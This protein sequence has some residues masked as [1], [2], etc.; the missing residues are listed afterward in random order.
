MYSSIVKKLSLALALSLWFVN[1]GPDIARASEALEQEKTE[2]AVRISHELTEEGLSAKIH[3]EAGNVGTLLTDVRM[4]KGSGVK[5]TG[6]DAKRETSETEEYSYTVTENGTYRFKVTYLEKVDSL[7]DVPILDEDVEQEEPGET[8][9]SSD[10]SKSTASEADTASPS[11]GGKADQELDPDTEETGKTEIN[12]DEEEMEEIEKPEN[13]DGAE[14]ENSEKPGNNDG[15]DP[16]NSEKPENSDGEDP[17]NS[18]AAPEAVWLKL[19]DKLFPPMEVWGAE[20]EFFW[21]EKSLIV[22]YTVDDIGEIKNPAELNSQVVTMESDIHGEGDEKTLTIPVDHNE[23]GVLTF[24]YALPEGKSGRALKI[25]F[26]KYVAVTGIP[27]GGMVEKS[28]W[29]TEGGVQYLYLYFSDDID[30]T[31]NIQVA[32]RGDIW[33][34]STNGRLTMNEREQYIASGEIQLGEFTAQAV[35]REGN[36]YG[37]AVIGPITTRK[38]TGNARYVFKRPWYNQQPLQYSI[39]ESSKWLEENPVRLSQ[40]DWYL[41]PDSIHYIYS[42]DCIPEFV[43]VK[44]YAPKNFRF[45]LE[46]NE[47]ETAGFIV[48]RS[49]EKGSYLDCN[50]DR[51]PDALSYIKQM[52]LV[53]EDGK[54]AEA[55]TVY[56]AA[57]TELTYNIFGEEK[58][59]E[60]FPTIKIITSSILL[61]YEDRMKLEGV[62]GNSYFSGT[63][64]R[65]GRSGNEWKAV[66]ISNMGTDTVLPDSRG[67]NAKLTFEFPYELQTTKWRLKRNNEAGDF[68]IKEAWAVLNTGVRVRCQNS[69]DAGNTILTLPAELQAGES[70]KRLEITLGS[71][72]NQ[73]MD[74]SYDGTV[75]YEDENG[76]P[77]GLYPGSPGK[78]VKIKTDFIYGEKSLQTE[79]FY[80][81]KG[82]GRE[83]LAKIRGLVPT[84]GLQIRPSYVF[85]SYNE[86]I[87]SPV[88]SGYGNDRALT[89]SSHELEGA[90]L[91]TEYPFQTQ[92]D[93]W[94]FMK[95]GVDNESLM[96]PLNQEINIS[97][98]RIFFDDGSSQDREVGKISSSKLISV[99]VPAGRRVVKTELYIKKIS[100]AGMRFE[101]GGKTSAVREDGSPY[102]KENVSIKS[103]L[104]YQDHEIQEKK[105]EAVCMFQAQ[106][107]DI[108]LSI[109]GESQII[110]PKNA[111]SH[112]IRAGQSWGSMIADELDNGI[113]TIEYP[114][115]VRPYNWKIRFQIGDSDKAR[116]QIKSATVYYDDST[117]ERIDV[118][119]GGEAVENADISVNVPEGRRVI[120]IEIQIKEARYAGVEIWT[121]F[122]TS[123]FMEDGSSFIGRAKC[124]LQIRGKSTSSESAA[125]VFL[126]TPSDW[127]QLMRLIGIE[128]NPDFIASANSS[129]S[130]W[131]GIAAAA[132]SQGAYAAKDLEFLIDQQT[133]SIC[134]GTI[135]ESWPGMEVHYKTTEGTE[136]VYKVTSYNSLASFYSLKSGEK[137]T[138]LS[139]VW[140]GWHYLNYSPYSYQPLFKLGYYY[141][142]SILEDLPYAEGS[143]D[144]KVFETKITGKSVSC[145]GVEGKEMTF[146]SQ[147]YFHE[148]VSQTIKPG[149]AQITLPAQSFQT[150]SFPFTLQTTFPVTVPSGA[151]LTPFGRVTYYVEWK[152]PQTFVFSGLSE[153]GYTGSMMKDREG[154]SWLKLEPAA[155]DMRNFNVWTAVTPPVITIK[156]KVLPGAKNQRHALTGRVYA[157]MK[158]YGESREELMKKGYAMTLEGLLPD[159]MGLCGD[160]DQGPRLYELTDQESS[161]MI[162]LKNLTGVTT[163]LGVAGSYEDGTDT[164][165]ILNSQRN[166]LNALVSVSS[167]DD[168]MGTYT[169]SLKLP[170]RGMEVKY[171][172]EGV[173]NTVTSGFDVFL[174]GP[175][176]AS[177]AL[178]PPQISYRLKENTEFV[179]KDSV[180]MRWSE[181]TEVRIVIRDLPAKQSQN[182]FMD[183]AAAPKTEEGEVSAYM[184]PQY[185]YVNSAGGTVADQYGR[186]ATFLYEDYQISGKAWQD[187]NENGI[188]ETGEAAY[189]GLLME[190]WEGDHRIKTTRTQEDGTYRFSTAKTKQM[191]VKA[192]PEDG[193]V[194]TAYRANAAQPDNNSDFDRTTKQAQLPEKIISHQENI[195]AGVVT[196]PI[197]TVPD[198]KVKKGKTVQAPASTTA[199]SGT[200]PRILFEEAKR[201]EI[202]TVTLDGAVTGVI[203]GGTTTSKA[204][205]VNSLGDRVEKEFRIRVGTNL[206]PVIT[207]HDWTAVEGDQIDDLWTGIGCVDP[208][209]TYPEIESPGIF[210]LG[211]G[212]FLSRTAEI[213]T[214]ENCE[215]GTGITVEEALKKRGVYY[216]RYHAV[217]TDSNEESAY[218][219]L[220]VYGKVRTTP[221]PAMHYFDDPATTL[222]AAL[223]FY[224]LD[225][226]DGR[227]IPVREGIT[228]QSPPTGSIGGISHVTWTAEHPMTNRISG[229]VTA[230]TGRSASQMVTTTTDSRISIQGDDREVAVDRD[231]A[232]SEGITA[233]YTHV[234]EGAPEQEIS[235]PVVIRDEQGKIVTSFHPQAPGIYRFF[236]TAEAEEIYENREAN[237][238]TV[239]NRTEK[240]VTVRVSGLPFVTARDILYVTPDQGRNESLIIGRMEAA[241][242]Y[243]RPDQTTAVIPEEDLEFTAVKSGSGIITSVRVRAPLILEGQTIWSNVK[244]TRV[245]IRELPQVI[246]AD[247]HL[248]QG[249]EFA[250]EQGVRIEPEDPENVTLTVTGTADTSH[251]GKYRITYHLKDRL[252]GAETD[253]SRDVYVHGRP[254]IEV[255]DSGIYTH[256]AADAGTVVN[257]LLGRG[258]GAVIRAAAYVD[259]TLPGGTTGRFPISVNEIQGEIPGFRP[260]V[261]NNWTVHLKVS[262]DSVLNSAIWPGGGPTAADGEKESHMAVADKKYQVTLIAGGHG[263]FREVSTLSVPVSHGKTVTLPEMIFEEGYRLSSWKDETGATVDISST[264]ILN[265]RTFR[266]EFKL[267]EYIVKFIGKHD[268]VIKTQ[269]VLHGYPA[270]APTNDRDVLNK[271]FDGW[272]ESF[273][274]VKS[275]L[276]VYALFYK[277]YSGGPKGP[278]AGADKGPGIIREDRVPLAKLPLELVLRLPEPEEEKII[279]RTLLPLPITGDQDLSEGTELWLLKLEPVLV[280]DKEKAG[281]AAADRQDHTILWK[282][283]DRAKHCILHWLLLACALLEMVCLIGRRRRKQSQKEK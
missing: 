201:P 163:I 29:K 122:K 189:P 115:E 30:Q 4:L 228:S 73:T 279:P 134:T 145:A 179:G 197:L 68:S 175:A 242:G 265:D 49:D 263:S 61:Q 99:D 95:I 75:A 35:D 15:E 191:S 14:M 180:G 281:Q 1:V 183:L 13:S 26:P 126:Y 127:T 41:Q 234:Q 196:L 40:Y 17:E 53:L 102:A 171:F 9:T 174:R 215:E 90:V 84:N 271:R 89:Y 165:S 128:S 27:E 159:V 140:K 247:M 110:Y 259:Y 282:E 133:A 10:A 229:G 32:Y 87:N 255:E 55:G 261:E 177:E 208:E 24:I 39:Y 166:D 158:A 220:R 118:E 31:V 19:A 190:L 93:S 152:S 187:R 283:H 238:D 116:A 214:N 12:E 86:I 200:S 251:L 168:I 254:V 269:V 16:E 120:K 246:T 58:T 184:A 277:T 204:Y 114:Y 101:M 264:P 167:R 164:V 218:A 97:K 50:L 232:F 188:R 94:K 74:L 124:K 18:E 211:T 34:S 219:V 267:K 67:E 231:V 154:N 77:I 60:S 83:D 274:C 182:I 3:I 44:V 106:A 181:V 172:Q 252:T 79:S 143:T 11:E 170:R 176:I 239:K 270:E 216:I 132:N 46:G 23:E 225:A 37:E 280:P 48:Q 192:V 139:V 199:P 276:D 8:G 104:N 51:Q 198:V 161:L 45:D 160:G 148:A 103:C 237:G 38:N 107:E 227:K 244:E 2:E 194:L 136:G 131:L 59:E 76:N 193:M 210:A 162:N 157:D 209:D 88:F 258:S 96:P 213:F 146:S 260:G 223:G 20:T 249:D 85:S 129:R 121:E 275:N 109:R 54:T 153:A 5:A 202:A 147:N 71:L 173:I 273:S 278:G 130:G 69:T 141:D 81:V 142:K 42:G 205:V 144:T 203:A 195:D 151:N 266:A 221:I 138:S 256:E 125:E 65:M 245:V 82:I 137:F 248:R 178:I 156:A 72:F 25:G 63:Q 206:G 62:R 43:R 91:T 243:Q 235:V 135:S 186:L 6:S 70:V 236:C 150:Q 224:Y 155:D 21:V 105:L 7:D 230:G 66:T 119:P 262:D 185:S 28:I 52:G 253:A 98:M 108:E 33:F 222:P 92:P 207:P 100:E 80:S 78:E 56:Q 240:T 22:D 226:E 217:D 47:A 123:E 241:A 111:Y 113:I 149:S 250:S 272:S 64:I 112:L 117:S 57:P 268:R 233:A 257:R 212:P 169:V 36:V